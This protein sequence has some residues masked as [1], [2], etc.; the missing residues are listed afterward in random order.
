[1]LSCRTVTEVIMVLHGIFEQCASSTKFSVPPFA[2]YGTATT[3]RRLD[4]ALA[5]MFQLLRTSF[6]MYFDVVGGNDVP[7]N[8]DFRR[9][10]TI[11]TPL[12]SA[13]LPSS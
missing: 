5:L 6:R 8:D 3:Q 9:C 13:R 4:T 7:E 2:P 1:M 11:R 12:T 10:Y